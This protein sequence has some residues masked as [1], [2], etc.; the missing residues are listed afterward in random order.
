MRES[1]ALYQG[2]LRR[3]KGWRQP[4]R[5]AEPLYAIVPVFNCYRWTTRWKHA[6]RAIKHFIDSGA[7]V[8]LIEAAFGEREFAM[9]E[10]AAHKI[11]GDAP[12]ISD[13]LAPNCR[14]DSERRGQHRYIQ[15]RTKSELWLKE[16]MI[17]VAAGFLPDD[18]KYIAWLDAD[19]LFSRPNWVGETIHLLQHYKF[20][21]MF[22]HAQDLD[23]HYQV[24]AQRPSFCYAYQEGLPM[25][26]PYYHGKK[27]LGAWSGLAWACTREAWDEVGGLIDIAI[28][29]GGDYHMAF[30]LIEEVKKS[31]RKDVHPGYR[32]ALLDWE[33]HCKKHIRKNIGCMTGTVQHMFHGKKKNRKY[34]NRHKLLAETQYNPAKDI[35]Y[36][37]QGLLQ[38]VDDGSERFIRLRDGMRAYGLSRDEDST[39]L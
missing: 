23:R 36:D 29:G 6:Q 26:D 38:L 21:Q 25:N 17:N 33:D 4:D 30:A 24:I 37:R 16:N 22:S 12:P 2:D 28:H 32:D 27:G 31:I 10:L 35:K 13:E 9:D 11:F 3:I 8:Y 7:V 39:E 5:V 19:I 20:I 1:P 14:H 34:G 15:M 18:A